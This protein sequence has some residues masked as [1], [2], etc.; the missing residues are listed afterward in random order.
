MTN[1][2]RART[3]RQQ[4]TASGTCHGSHC[5]RPASGYLC[6][7]CARAQAPK[8]AQIAKQWWVTEKF[9]EAVVLLQAGKC[10]T[11]GGEKRRFHW[12]NCAKCRSTMEKAA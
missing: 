1:A 7:R 3:W 5:T 2:E 4:R 6:E 9:L 12:W 8:K 10:A 11:C